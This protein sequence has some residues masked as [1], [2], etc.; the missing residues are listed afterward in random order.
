MIDYSETL[1]EWEPGSIL[2]FRGRGQ[3]SVQEYQ[4]SFIKFC[5]RVQI[6]E[7]RVQEIFAKISE[8]DPHPRGINNGR[9]KF[10]QR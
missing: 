4:L 2:I 7:I 9:R 8:Q 5:C 1:K 3:Q 6:F 10:R